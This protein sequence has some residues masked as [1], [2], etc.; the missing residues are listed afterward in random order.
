M[1]PQ[2]TL[3]R[4]ILGF[5][6]LVFVGA[7]AGL[8]IVTFETL[9]VRESSGSVDPIRLI[10]NY[11]RCKSINR[12]GLAEA[13]FSGSGVPVASDFETMIKEHPQLQVISAFPSDIW[14]LK[15]RHLDYFCLSYDGEKISNHPPRSNSKVRFCQIKRFLYGIPED[16]KEIDTNTL[17]TERSLL[18][19]MNIPYAAPFP[20]DWPNNLK[21]VDEILGLF[22][23]IDPKTQHIRFHCEHGKGRT[24]LISVMYDMYLNSKRVS[25][26]DIMTRNFCQSGEDLMD[27]KE[28]KGGTWTGKGLENRRNIALAFY[29]YMN[30]PN[31]YGHQSFTQWLEI[32]KTTNYPYIPHH[33]EVHKHVTRTTDL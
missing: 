31:G 23:K 32:K 5:V 12:E 10:Q 33:I 20:K 19:K 3:T 17:Y 7:L 16:I 4:F 18:K 28:H 21:F 15:G 6:I 9:K 29:D 13:N 30:D 26:E 8:Y 22:D 2:R 1:W 14:Y 24:T 11:S 25:V 27:I